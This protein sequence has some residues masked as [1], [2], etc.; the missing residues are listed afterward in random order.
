MPDMTFGRG[1]YGVPT[2]FHS[3]PGSNPF[4]PGTSAYEYQEG[5]N[6]ARD[7]RIA[8][9]FA[10]EQAVNAQKTKILYFLNNDRRNFLLTYP[11]ERNFVVTH[12]D[13]HL[14]ERDDLALEHPILD[15]QRCKRLKKKAERN[16]MLIIFAIIMI[17]SMIL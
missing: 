1:M 5:I 17:V 11:N 4:V 10:Q 14:I 13:Y 9:E 15:C 7:K 2:P 16:E 6:K 12:N 8:R 3:T